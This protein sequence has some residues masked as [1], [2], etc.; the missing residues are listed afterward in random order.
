MFLACCGSVVRPG[1]AFKNV[2]SDRGVAHIYIG[3]NRLIELSDTLAVPDRP[4]CP[5]V[6]ARAGVRTIFRVAAG[7][8]LARTMALT[9]AGHVTGPKNGVMSRLAMRTVRCSI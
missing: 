2:T 4:F 1:R 5:N 7:A 3:A 8:C 6:G 9:H